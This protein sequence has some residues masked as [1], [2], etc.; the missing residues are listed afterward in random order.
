MFELDQIGMYL[1]G[2]SPGT[3]RE[4]GVRL[5]MVVKATV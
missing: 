3:E 1:L 4:A 2:A 5:P